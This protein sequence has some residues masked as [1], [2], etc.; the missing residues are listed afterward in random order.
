MNW[1]DEKLRKADCKTMDKIR[2]DVIKEENLRKGNRGGK[3][4]GA[5]RPKKEPTTTIRIPCI[6]KPI[7]ERYVKIK[8]LKF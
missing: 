4:P 1:I 3:R 8:M 5:G 2:E 7:I 6:L